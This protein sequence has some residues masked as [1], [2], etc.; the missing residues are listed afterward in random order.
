MVDHRG[1]AFGHTY[2]Y[3][4]LCAVRK[5][6]ACTMHI[7]VY[8][9]RLLLL[10]VIGFFSFKKLVEEEKIQVMQ[11]SIQNTRVMYSVFSSRLNGLSAIRAICSRKK[12]GQK[13]EPRTESLRLCESVAVLTHALFQTS[14]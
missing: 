6:H 7:R 12:S 11:S 5:M 3:L 8:A 14:S 9:A 13:I 10:L 4:L 2:T 1:F